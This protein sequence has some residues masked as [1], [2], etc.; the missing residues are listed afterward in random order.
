M[1]SYNDDEIT[2][3]VQPK[4]IDKKEHLLF[5]VSIFI[6]V[7][8]LLNYIILSYVY[9]IIG[10]D[11]N[12]LFTFLLVFLSFSYIFGAATIRYSNKLIS[13]VINVFGS[14]WLGMSV[15]GVFTIILTEFLVFINLLG[16]DKKPVFALIIFLALSFYA[17]VNAMFIY[18][19]KFVIKFS[20]IKKPLRLVQ[21]SDLH[22]G[23]AHTRN[24]LLNVVNKIVGQNPDVVV[25][26]G[27]LIDGKHDY[28]EDYFDIL[29]KINV[30]VLMCTGNHDRMTGMKTVYKL[31]KKSGVK[32]L[33]DKKLKVKGVSFFGV[34]DTE[35]PR[36]F[37]K[38]VRELNPRVDEF[39]VLLF[40]RP[41][42][43][44]K[45]SKLNVDLM[46]SGH[47][48]GGQIFPLNLLQRFYYVKV[49]GL[50]KNKGSF[51]YV[52][53]GTGWWGPPMRLGSKNEIT[54]F[55]LVPDEK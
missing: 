2:T 37:V 49:R 43:F 27:D 15:L 9:S 48:H 19:R 8:I 26:T 31:L 29:S 53:P 16:F 3:M 24:Y 35:K 14:L 39:N 47:T 32:I 6:F 44:K 1:K 25:I 11:R 41:K 5:R 20:K 50:F 55:D 10:V 38:K 21:V 30:P 23:A 7:Y 18:V 42:K 40:H 33:S 51:L 17:V 52:S 34:D 12:E 46:L 4:S 28:E 13:R 36:V 22:V 45:V 54:V